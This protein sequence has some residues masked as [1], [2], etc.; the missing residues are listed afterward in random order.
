LAPLRGPLASF[1][2]VEARI[3]PLAFAA[4]PNEFIKSVAAASPRGDWPRGFS[5]E[6]PYWTIVG[7]DGGKDQGLLGEDG[8]IELG[9]G[10]P[11]IEP[12]VFVDGKRVGWADVEAVPSLQDGY[13]PMP[14]VAW[15]HPAFGLDIGAFA[16]GDAGAPRLAARYRLRNTSASARDYDFAL[17]LRPLQVNP[18]SQ[19]LNTTGGVSP[20][21]VV[22]ADPTSGRDG[23]PGASGPSWSLHL[24]PGADDVVGTTFDRGDLAGI[25]F[26][27]WPTRRTTTLLVRDTA[28]MAG[29]A[30]RYRVHLMPW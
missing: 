19:F 12:F 16:A 24:A 15:R 28:G 17:V 25:P 29:V 3:E 5:G 13:L 21:R 2:L 8:A 22:A 14:S 4:T 11:S 7:V 30:W 20:L 18:P 23:M 27:T 10:G 26:G 9:K 1:G 6:Q